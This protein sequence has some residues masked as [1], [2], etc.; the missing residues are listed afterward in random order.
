MACYTMAIDLS[1]DPVEKSLSYANRAAAHL[2]V[3][4]VES[5]LQDSSEGIIELECT[6]L[7]E[8]CALA[9]KINPKFVK[10][11]DRR[12]RIF[13]KLREWNDALDD[14]VA[15]A[16]LDEFQSNKYISQIEEILK[17][18]SETEAR[19]MI[20]VFLGNPVCIAHVCF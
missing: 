12:S 2:G 17:I 5:A 6:I 14:A 11:L 10:A 8:S 15:A 18:I 20:V 13:Q 7:S 9:L 3:D 16:L 19:T 1:I 4:D